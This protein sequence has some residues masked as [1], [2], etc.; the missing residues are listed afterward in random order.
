MTYSLKRTMAEL[1]HFIPMRARATSSPIKR[2]ED[3]SLFISNTQP[4]DDS[5]GRPPLR[6]SRPSFPLLLPIHLPLDYRRIQQLQD[7]TLHCHLR[8]KSSAWSRFWRS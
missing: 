8:R 3:S 4:Q 7:L 1:T 2:D 5:H 6:R